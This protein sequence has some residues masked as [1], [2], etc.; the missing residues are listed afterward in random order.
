MPE[1]N[2][3]QAMVPAGAR[4]IENTRGS[5][6]GLWLEEGD[7]VVLLLPGPPRELNPMLDGAGSMGLCATRSLA[8]RSCGA[9]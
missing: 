7:S 9:S 6:P 4:V 5:A 3:R 2:R 1:I 8:R